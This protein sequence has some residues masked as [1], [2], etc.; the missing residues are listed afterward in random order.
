MA[1]RIPRIES[2]FAGVLP[3]I[4]RFLFKHHHAFNIIQSMADTLFVI[5]MKGRLE[6]VNRA[7]LETLDYEEKN[8]LGKPADILFAS[9]LTPHS[10]RSA[11]G[12]GWWDRLMKEGVARNVEMT[13]RTRT[14]REIPVSFTAS[15]IKDRRNRASGAVFLNKD[16]AAFKEHISGLESERDE[17]RYRVKKL[18]IFEGAKNELELEVARRTRELT[19]ALTQLGQLRR[20]L[21]RDEKKTDLEGLFASAAHQIKN[22]LTVIGMTVQHLFRNLKSD[23]SEVDKDLLKSVTRKIDEIKETTQGLIHFARTYQLDRRPAR[24]ADITKKILVFVGPKCAGQNVTISTEYA[25]DMPEIE[26]DSPKL[27]EVIFNLIDNALKAMREK[28]ELKVEIFT[29]NGEAVIRV[30]DTGRGIGQ[31]HLEKIFRPFY[32][33]NHGSGLGLFIAMRIVEAHGGEICV[34]SSPGIGTVFEVRLPYD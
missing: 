5:D 26:V 12:G 25:D 24:L 30:G 8:L 2:N 4:N 10:S 32:S 33:T 9:P 6:G 27:E 16:V 19:G 14:G 7:L 34:E 20:K 23:D 21:M 3:G 11:G 13:Y 1:S 17:L 15:V 28:G 22:P 18:E 31:E 29:R